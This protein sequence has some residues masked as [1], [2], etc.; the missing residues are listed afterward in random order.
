MYFAE[1]GLAADVREF[2]SRPI[3]RLIWNEIKRYQEA[4]FVVFVENVSG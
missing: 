2:F 4:D 3:P 1:G